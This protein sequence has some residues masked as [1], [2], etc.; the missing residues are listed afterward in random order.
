MNKEVMMSSLRMPMASTLILKSLE[1]LIE[2]IYAVRPRRGYMVECQLNDAFSLLVL[3]L[4]CENAAA[5][6][7]KVRNVAKGMF[8]LWMSSAW[9]SKPRRMVNKELKSK[10]VGF[11]MSG[12]IVRLQI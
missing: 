11:V 9:I 4:D 1:S 7:D 8:S 2:G 3:I 10:F 12:S 5:I 6:L